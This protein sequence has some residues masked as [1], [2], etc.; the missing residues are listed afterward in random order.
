MHLRGTTQMHSEGKSPPTRP[1]L[2]QLQ[3]ERLKDSGEQRASGSEL[4]ERQVDELLYIEFAKELRRI[5]EMGI[6]GNAM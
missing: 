1:C 3:T 4:P 2:Q 6:E 5:A